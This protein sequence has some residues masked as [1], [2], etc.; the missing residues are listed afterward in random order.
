MICSPA[1]F[2]G[3]FTVALVATLGLVSG[4]LIGADKPEPRVAVGKLLS[5][6][7]SVIARKQ[8]GQKFEVIKQGGAL[9]SGDLLVALPGAL[10]ES[11]NGQVQLHLDADLDHR[12]PYP[13][14]E[15]A[16]VLHD[17]DKADL[18]FTLD[19]GR[20]DVLDNRDDGS[21]HIVVRFW[22]QT[23]EWTTGT[24]KARVALELYGRWPR[25]AFFH[26]E[27][28]K[29]DDPKE[30]PV[31]ALDMVVLY[32]DVSFMQGGKLMRMHAPPGPA[33]YEWDSSGGGDPS[34]TRLDK[35]PE[36]ADPETKLTAEGK[37]RK[38]IIEQMRASYARQGVEAAIT[39]ALD[40][41]DGTLR[42]IG[43][44]C[45]GA[46]D[47]LPGLIDALAN[48]QH[49]EVR[50][51]AV[52]T[53]RHWIGRTDG[54]DQKLYEALQKKGYSAAHAVM[55][56]NL[57][58]TPGPKELTRP[59]L[60]EALIAYLGHDKLAI[61]ELADWHLSRLVPAGR[62]IVYDAAGPKAERDAAIKKWQELIPEGKLPPKAEKDIKEFKK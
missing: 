50:D 30:G 55:I 22:G 45:M 51:I 49:P 1:R 39:Q 27:E 58:H 35:L 23:W 41:G 4:V 38:A 25:G 46:T 33:L 44:V 2:L 47:D 59:A 12:S 24:K 11:K 60:Y 18:D 6:T 26:K 28:A 10:V 52:R 37:K 31:G 40:S 19:R 53:L 32:G 34:P 9:Y 15:C 7:G 42:R 21:S 29:K 54:Q 43:V 62:D 56:V 3:R 36:W 5:P 48:P 17:N 16:V 13:I 57:L 14:L 8:G 20:V 61:R